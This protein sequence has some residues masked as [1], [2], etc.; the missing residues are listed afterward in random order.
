MSKEKR[1]LRYQEIV[2][3]MGEPT[4]DVQCG[5]TEI[6]INPDKMEEMEQLLIELCR[7]RGI[8]EEY[9]YLGAIWENHWYA[10]VNEPVLFPNSKGDPIPGCYMRVF[11]KGELNGQKSVFLLPVL[12]DGRILLNVA[13][14]STVRNWTVEGPGTATKE[15]ETHAEAIERCV[16]EKLGRRL[17]LLRQLGPS[18]GVISERGIMGAAVPVY[19]ATVSDEKESDASDLNVRGHIALSIKEVMDGFHRGYID[20]GNKRCVC[21]DGYTSYALL[22]ALAE[23]YLNF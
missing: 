3:Q 7:S 23:G 17:I 15:N 22:L 5:E 12:E 14:R 13:Y 6:I 18:G 9:V 20:V 1:H 11:F 10:V 19:L 4:G 2:K 16:R 21:Q 8:P